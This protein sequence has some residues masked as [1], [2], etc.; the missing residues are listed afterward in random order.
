MPTGA[1]PRHSGATEGEITRQCQEVCGA[2]FH[3]AGAGMPPAALSASVVLP[4][5]RFASIVA[6]KSFGRHVTTTPIKLPR[7]VDSCRCQRSL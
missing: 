5:G 1:V 2:R 6:A 4:L 3:L 7:A